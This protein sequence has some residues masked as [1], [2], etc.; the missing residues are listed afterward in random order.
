MYN[1]I[2]K[3]YSPNETWEDS[4][5]FTLEHDRVFEYTD[6]HISSNYRNDLQGLKEF[7][8]LFSY[9]G[10]EG[11]ARVGRID[12]VTTVGRQVR[13]VYKLYTRFPAVPIY[14][15]HTYRLFGCHNQL[16]CYR[17]HW[18][19]KDG[20][21][22]GIIDELP[23]ERPAY[24]GSEVSEDIMNRLWGHKSRAHYRVF[25]SHSAQDKSCT[26][27]IAGELAKLGHRTFV[28][29]DDIQA[30]REW[31]D[32]IV[33]ALSTMTHF[34]G[35]ITDDF[36][37]RVWTDQEVGY[38]FCRKDVKRIFVKLSSADPKGL[39]GFE[40]AIPGG[41]NIADRIQEVMTDR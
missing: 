38:A 23:A 1:L 19:V 29:H 28:A 39:A 11:S 4:N 22:F 37:S 8:C 15:K 31:R 10:F 2:V 21:L 20:D 17:T 24:T 41:P 32:E 27:K 35:L 7:P 13:I 9:E 14:D 5:E 36:H 25:L 33:H 18:A 6:K 26:T 30:T 3:I 34:V 16:E 40:Q 12:A